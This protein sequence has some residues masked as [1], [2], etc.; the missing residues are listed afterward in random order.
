MQLCLSAFGSAGDGVTNDASALRAC[1][2]EAASGNAAFV[3]IEP[4]VY[5]VDAPEPVPLC[6][7]LTVRAY[8]A[9]FLF[10]REL[11]DADCRRMFYGEDLTDVD[12]QGGHF[13]GYVYDPEVGDLDNDIDP[14]TPFE[15]RPED[16]VCPLCL[17]G[18]EEFTEE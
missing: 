13:V 16:W 14:G 1:F 10:P 9:T 4:G 18:K 12:W 3:T 7:H 8:G 5:L 17:V 15:D 2:T 11:G 6:S